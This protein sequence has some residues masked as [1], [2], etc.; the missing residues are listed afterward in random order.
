MFL[1]LH[2]LIIFCVDEL[3]FY[4]L[5]LKVSRIKIVESCE[6]YN[7]FFNNVLLLSIYFDVFDCVLR[8]DELRLVDNQKENL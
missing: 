4:F 2:Q 3:I 5:D 6:C 7:I 8:A 1:F